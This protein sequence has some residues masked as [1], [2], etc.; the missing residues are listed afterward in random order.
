MEKKTVTIR[1]GGYRALASAIILQAIEDIVMA[2]VPEKE[3]NEAMKFFE[4]S[5]FEFISEALGYNSEEIRRRLYNQ[6]AEEYLSRKYRKTK[7][8]A[9][10]Y[11]AKAMLSEIKKKKISN[12][13]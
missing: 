10:Y 11:Y 9:N 1:E 5:W 7:S 4:D 13:Y 3:R 6:I 2:N 8:K 12:C